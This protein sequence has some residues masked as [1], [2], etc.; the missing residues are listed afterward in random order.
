L[1]GKVHIIRVA[2]APKPTTSGEKMCRKYSGW[3]PNPIGLNI[4]ESFANRVT[5]ALSTMRQLCLSES[6]AVTNTVG[7][8][9]MATSYLGFPDTDPKRRYLCV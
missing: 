8:R 9:H 4:R 3:A 5:A 2:S 6:I 1:K 7:H